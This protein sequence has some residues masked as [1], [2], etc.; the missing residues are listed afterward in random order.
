MLAGGAVVALAASAVL[1]R[2]AAPIPSHEIAFWRLLIAACAVLVVATARRQFPR[3][4]RNDLAVLAGIGFI[5]AA[6]F[7]A[8]VASL[9]FTT[10]AHSLSLIYTAPVFIG[11]L[12]AWRLR[13]YPRRPQ[14][15]GM[16]VA[17]AGIAILA[18]FEPQVELSMLIGDG[19]ALV[20]AVTLAIYSVAGRG[21]RDRYSLLTYAAPV[22]GLAALWL[23]PMAIATF[24]A[25]AYSITSIA[26]VLALG[27][28][29]LGV[30]HT[31]YN[32]ALRYLPAATANVIATQEVTGG[33][34]LAWLL[35]GEVPSPVALIGAAITLA[36]VLL[37][38]IF[39]RRAKR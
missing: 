32:A 24:D 19:L 20:S 5:T 22:Y 28:I 27:L 26:A 3:Y 10:V 1:V 35:L 25:T 30:G 9:T 2:W 36:G 21:L 34:V 33:V 8:Y 17:V 37:V 14:V 18:G 12:A 29:P 11:I 16:V 6:H 39:E 38:L 31:L 13:E 15:A 7:L 4:R 23:L